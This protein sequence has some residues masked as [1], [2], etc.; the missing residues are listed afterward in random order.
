MDRTLG[1]CTSVEYSSTCSRAVGSTIYRQTSLIVIHSPQ[2]SLV[3][4]WRYR[5]R[6]GHLVK[7]AVSSSQAQLFRAFSADA[8]GVFRGLANIPLGDDCPRRIQ[9]AIV[10]S[11]LIQ[12]R[13]RGHKVETMLDQCYSKAPTKT[14]EPTEFSN[15]LELHTV[16]RNRKEDR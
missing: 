8:A 12:Q 14:M 9:R 6:H 13:T 5:S 4:F 3:R 15:K 1:G 2:I 7:T 16:Q 10:S 11:R